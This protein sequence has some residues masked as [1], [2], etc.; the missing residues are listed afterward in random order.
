M[1]R[2]I[3]ALL[4][5]PAVLALLSLGCFPDK[6]KPSP[7]PEPPQRAVSIVVISDPAD[8]GDLATYADATLDKYADTNGHQLRIHPLDVVD[9]TKQTPAYLKPYI[10]AAK[11]GKL[12]VAFV[13]KS[14]KIK[15]T[16]EQPKDSQAIIALV[17]KTV[18]SADTTDSF[19]AGGQW[20]KLGGL[21][22][23]LAGAENRWTVEGSEANEPI[24]PQA[25]WKEV[26]LTRLIWSVNNQAAYSSCCPTSGCSVIEI[27]ANRSGL[28]KFNLSALDGYYRINGGRDAG[29]SLEDFLSIATTQGVATTDF[30][31][32][33]GWRKPSL[34]IGYETSRAKHRVLKASIC[35][36]WEAI[37]SALQRNKPVHFGLLVDSGF[38]PND[39][40]VIGPKR[41]HSG[42]GHALVMVGLRKVNG[43]WYGIL[44][45]SWG[46]WGG[47]KDGTVPN[48]CCLLHP[49]YVELMFGAFAYSAVVSPSDDPV[50]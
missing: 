14:G 27:L 49:S 31:N 29:A 41:G 28:R 19:W 44:L 33:Q 48:G 21:R 43:E 42:G 39:K 26:D 45:N 2:I 25:Q 4:A 17:E 40:G 16:L 47:S 24:I 50:Q 34:K 7:E 8:F 6:P 35:T 20:R 36:S 46:D 37:G 30:C 15:A 13:G 32:E 3:A 11:K 18:G 10:E 38:S 5:M 1:K 22:P 9:E 12:P 23:M